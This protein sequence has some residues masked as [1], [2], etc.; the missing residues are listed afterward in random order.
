MTMSSANIAN[1]A[2]SDARAFYESGFKSSNKRYDVD[3]AVWYKRWFGLAAE[4]NER[5]KGASQALGQVRNDVR[6]RR[7]SRIRKGQLLWNMAT[8]VGNCDELTNVAC[9]RAKQEGAKVRELRA[10]ILTAPADH[11]F[12]IYGDAKV[13]AELEGRRVGSLAGFNGGHQ[14]FVIDP[15]TNICCTL[16]DYPGKIRDKMKKWHREGKRISWAAGPNGPGFYPPSEGA[17]Q[18]A[19]AFLDACLTL[20]PVG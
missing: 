13:L 8:T 12:C 19:T 10:A 14:V 3:N 20:H 18:Y 17:G 2:F 4:A 1:T 16:C 11:V 7:N 5:R 6:Y 15:W 9:Y